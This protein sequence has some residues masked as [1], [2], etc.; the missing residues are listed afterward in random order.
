MIDTVCWKFLVPL[1][2]PIGLVDLGN[3]YLILTPFCF[4]AMVN[5]VKLTDGFDGLAGGA[6]ALSFIG[7][8]VAVL[9][10]CP[11]LTV[12]G[13]SMAGACIGFL[14]HNKYKASVCMGETGT[15]ALGGAL[16]AMAACTGMFLPLFIS[17]GVF[18]LEILSIMV[19]VLY[20]LATRRKYL[21]TRRL[22]RV[23]PLHRLLLSYGLHEPIIVSIAYVVSGILAL[24]AGYVGLISA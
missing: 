1:P 4:I 12:F 16:A 18:V 10:V 23:T 15:L 11:E 6:A 3:L 5:G 2:Q 9:A 14:F 24:V 17:S 22:L 7:M 8:A 13:A 21:D 19:Q 20:L